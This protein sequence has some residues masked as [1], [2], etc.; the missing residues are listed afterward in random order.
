MELDNAAAEVCLGDETPV[1]PPLPPIFATRICEVHWGGATVG[2]AGLREAA[3]VQFGYERGGPSAE[4][5]EL[6]TKRQREAD[7][8]G[9]TAGNFSLSKGIRLSGGVRGAGWK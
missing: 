5:V 3:T 2:G 4:A 8:E 7:T 1:A 6:S 9:S